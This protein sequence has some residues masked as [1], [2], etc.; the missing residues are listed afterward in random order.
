M[1]PLASG[2]PGVGGITPKANLTAVLVDYPP[3]GPAAIL[4]R[5][6]PGTQLS[7]DLL[8]SHATLPIAGGEQALRQAI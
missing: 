4:T 7:M 3:S 8:H 5:G 1:R 6:W 2:A